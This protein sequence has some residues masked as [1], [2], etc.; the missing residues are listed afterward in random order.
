MLGTKAGRCGGRCSRATRSASRST[1]ASDGVR[2][3][4]WSSSGCSDVVD[5]EL[6]PRHARALEPRL[7]PA[8]DRKPGRRP[9]PD[10]RVRPDRAVRAAGGVRIGRRGNGRSPL[11]QRVPRRGAAAHRD[12]ARRF[13]RGDVRSPGDPRRALSPRRARRRRSRSGDRRLADGGVVRAPREH[14]SGVRPAR[15]RSAAFR[16]WA[17]RRRAVEHLQVAR[18]HVD[19]HRREPGRRLP[20]PVRRNGPARAGG[21]PALRDPPCARR[22]R[23]DDRRDHRRMG[24]A[25]RRARDRPHPQRGRSRVRADLQRRGH[26]RGPAVRGARDARRARRPRVR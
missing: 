6:P 18:R 4:C 24:R 3:S 12:L 13:P 16:Y 17:E 7:R 26:L 5:G 9:R 8:L 21:R 22:E 19:G 20:P 25:A 14:R 15:H 23:G 11:H 10:L 1:S 2:S